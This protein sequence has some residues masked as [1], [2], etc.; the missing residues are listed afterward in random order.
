MKLKGNLLTKQ[1]KI[2]DAIDIYET[3]KNSSFVKKNKNGI[4]LLG[5][6]LADLYYLN[7]EYDKALKEYEALEKIGKNLEWII[8]QKINIFKIKNDIKNLK[9]SYEKLKEIAPDSFWFKQL[10]KVKIDNVG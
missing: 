6:K 2:S 5:S 10:K 4:S 3:I 9:K 1:N 7:E 8:F